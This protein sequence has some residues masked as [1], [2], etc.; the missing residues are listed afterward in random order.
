MVEAVTRATALAPMADA[1]DTASEGGAV[2][3]RECPFITL[4]NLRSNVDGS[5]FPT[6]VKT[7]L[8]LAVPEMPNMVLSGDGFHI[9]WLGPDEWLI[10]G[11]D[12]EH[13]AL[14]QRLE[15]ALRGQH[16]SVVDISSHR[17]VLELS[18]PRA[19]DVLE[20]G[21]RLDLHSSAFAPGR[22]AGTVIA[23]TQVYLEQMNDGPTYRLYV[24]RSFSRHL[25]SWLLDAMAEYS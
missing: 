17:V 25:A 20:K 22:C 23:N 12:G 10:V 8:G 18:G 3:L 21:C 15:G 9:L 24:V 5:A 2:R 7:A 13:E 6:A 1:L 11:E 19:R 16:M 14:I 4:I